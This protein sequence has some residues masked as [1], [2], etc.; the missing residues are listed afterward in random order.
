[1]LVLYAIDF[2]N[3]TS[4]K[5]LFLIFRLKRKLSVQFSKT[6]RATNNVKTLPEAKDYDDQSNIDS[7]KTL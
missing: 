1:M 3:A 6:K 2:V 7:S 5:I 4:L